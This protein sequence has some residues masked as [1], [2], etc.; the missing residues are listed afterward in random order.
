ME[1]ENAYYCEKCRESVSLNILNY[2]A[3][4]ISGLYDCSVHRLV[5]RSLNRMICFCDKYRKSSI[6]PRG[7]YLFFVVLEGDL[8]ERGAFF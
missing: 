2:A 1:G 3:F 8:A 6:M 7:T 5:P 4:F